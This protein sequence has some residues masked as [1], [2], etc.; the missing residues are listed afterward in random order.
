MQS[1][2]DQ[3]RPNKWRNRGLV[4][5]IVI[6]VLLIGSL[7]ALVIAGLIHAVTADERVTWTDTES[8]YDAT[9]LVNFTL[10]EC[11]PSDS[12]SS[13]EWSSAVADAEQALEADWRDWRA[14]EDDNLV[15]TFTLASIGD[16]YVDEFSG[17]V[18]DYFEAS[19]VCA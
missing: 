3:V 14:N 8:W 16:E 18:A 19:E 1:A 6:L 13:E 11:R 7:I 12:L 10:L 17:H 9:P 5:S 4:A 15:V 2:N